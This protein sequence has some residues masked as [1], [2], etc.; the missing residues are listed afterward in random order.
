MEKIHARGNH[1]CIEATLQVMKQKTDSFIFTNLID[2]D[3]L[4]GHRRD[5]FGYYRCLREFDA[6]LPSIIENLGQNDLL[7]LTADHGNDPCFRG[8]DHTREYVPILVFSKSG[9][10]NVNLETRTTFADVGKTV[11]DFFNVNAPVAGTG[12]L[13]KIMYLENHERR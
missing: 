9:R 11:L 5:P 6:V 7:M 1:A 10:S 8:T 4:Y 2:F 12:F 13:E 3:M